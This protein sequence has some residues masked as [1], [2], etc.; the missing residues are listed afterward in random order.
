MKRLIYAI[1]FGLISVSLFSGYLAKPGG[2]DLGLR[3]QTKANPKEVEKKSLG[4]RLILPSNVWVI[5]S[6]C[7]STSGPNSG[8]KKKLDGPRNRHDNR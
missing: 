7:P 3:A 1:C 6:Y 8:A 2:N 4:P 5:G